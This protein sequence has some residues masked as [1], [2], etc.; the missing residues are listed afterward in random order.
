MITRYTIFSLTVLSAFF[1]NSCTE[2]YIPQPGEVE[3]EI[4]ISIGSQF[5]YRDEDKAYDFLPYITNEG[6]ATFNNRKRRFALVGKKMNIGDQL[7]VKP[8]AKMKYRRLDRTHEVILAIPAEEKY[9]TI[10]LTGYEALITEYY[11]TKQIVEYWYANRYG[12]GGVSDL[13]WS[14][15]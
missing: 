5:E 10:E 12:L 1:L 15:L 7:Y 2:N 11:S 4:D 3:M 14:A 8:I 13:R 9:R 6:D